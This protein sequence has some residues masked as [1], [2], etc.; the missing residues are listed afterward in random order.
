MSSDYSISYIQHN[1]YLGSIFNIKK[2]RRKSK[3]YK[4]R[5]LL[6]IMFFVGYL[7]TYSKLKGFEVEYLSLTFFSILACCLLLTR[8]NPPLHKKLPI[9]IILAVFMVAYYFKF[10]WMVYDPEI[11]GVGWVMRKLY[12]LIQSPTVLFETF[13]TISYAFITFCV[14]AWFLLGHTRSLHMEPSKRRINYRAVISILLW[15]IPI[16]MGITAYV[17]YIT[18]I[19]RMGADNPYLPF[20]LAGWITYIRKMFIP[21]LLLLLIWSSDKVDLRK[22]FTFGII[23]LFLHGL[24]IMLLSASKGALLLPFVILIILFLVTR[25]VTKKRVLLFCIILLITII[26]FPIISYYRN[27]RTADLHVPIGSSL[28][29]AIINI[30]SDESFSFFNLGKEATA[31]VM[32]RFTG[33]DSIVQIR[34]ANF[35]PLY[36]DVFGMSVSKFFTFDVIG[37]PPNAIQGMAPSFLGWFYL[38]GGNGLVVIAMAFFVFLSWFCWRL[39]AKLK[40]RCLPVAQSLFLWWIFYLFSEGVLDRLYLGF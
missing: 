29:A 9:W 33:A 8:L 2:A 22:C 40:L 27:L 20:R 6:L 1:S 14:T 18:G 32:L 39:L 3:W 12:S 36:T 15:L 23:L 26:L 17:M 13:T 10:Y 25:R 35:P 37:Y 7:A 28:V 4:S 30:S 19:G 34:G 38:V 24:S 31:S 16:L 11:L 5:W 21:A